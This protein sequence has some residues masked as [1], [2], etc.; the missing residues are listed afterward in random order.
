M[1]TSTDFTFFGIG[2]LKCLV[3]D[4]VLCSQHPANVVIDKFEETELH[5]N[6]AIRT[7]ARIY[8]EDSIHM[9]IHVWTAYGLLSRM[10]S[11]VIIY[12]IATEARIIQELR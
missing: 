10:W 8:L 2:S 3:E 1:V 11:P 6:L 12:S 4:F 7:N 5:K 9:A